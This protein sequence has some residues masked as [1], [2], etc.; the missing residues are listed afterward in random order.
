MSPCSELFTCKSGLPPADRAGHKA[1]AAS[2]TPTAA[3]TNPH[4]PSALIGPPGLLEARTT[5][6]TA[7][8]AIATAPIT[9]TLRH[10]P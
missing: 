2:R 9:T 1:T 6:T 7:T 4:I 8:T 5:I 10:M 3:N